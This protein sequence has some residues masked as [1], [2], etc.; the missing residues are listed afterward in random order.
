MKNSFIKQFLSFSKWERRGILFL[1][2]L[3]LAIAFMPLFFEKNWSVSKSDLSAFNAEVNAFMAATLLDTA[4]TEKSFFD[5]KTDSQHS[6]HSQPELFPFNPNHLPAESWKKLGLKDWQIRI[7]FNFEKKGGR[8]YKKED[9]QHIYGMRDE[10]YEQ[11]EPFI[12]IP[13]EP[14][15]IFA[16]EKRDTARYHP[17][18]QIHL[19]LAA[20]DSSSLLQISGIGPSFAS[21]IVKYRDHLGGFYKKEQLLEVYGMDSIRFQQI[22]KY[23]NIGD[24]AHLKKININTILIPQLKHPY[25]NYN[26]IN[27]LVNYRRMHGKYKS[28]SEIRKTVVITPEIYARIR[29][30]LCLE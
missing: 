3:I 16:F 5:K 21:R 15:K 12:Q 19:D 10:L 17:K 2:I 8:F 20:A 6:G 26:V 28:I 30:Y 4:E 18:P 25:F 7:V 29:P 13:Q 11:W 24:T 27:A 23:L 14:K 1:V 9:L 22:A